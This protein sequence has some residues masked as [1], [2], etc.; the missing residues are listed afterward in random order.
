MHGF[1]SV[2]DQRVV[3]SLDWRHQLLH[4]EVDP[5]DHLICSISILRYTW[6]QSLTVV[7]ERFPRH[8]YACRD[9]F[10]RAGFF[11]LKN[12]DVLRQI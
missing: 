6:L 3:L 5:I 9:F 12:L 4:G 11:M 8:P 10:V 1:L 7:L 2:E